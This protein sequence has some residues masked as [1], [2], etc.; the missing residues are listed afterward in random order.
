MP[1]NS[2]NN[3]N[4]K[5]NND[6]STKVGG[7]KPSV[8]PTSTS[9][10]PATSNSGE[11]E[12]N[13]DHVKDLAQ[14]SVQSLEQ[15]IDSGRKLAFEYVGSKRGDVEG[16]IEEIVK[17]SQD[18][19]VKAIDSTLSQI[20]GSVKRYSSEMGTSINAG[21]KTIDARPALPMIA[22]LIG[23]V[24][25]GLFLGSRVDFSRVRGKIESQVGSLKNDF[26]KKAA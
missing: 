2:N 1:N 5:K 13:L 23:G 4:F 18:K 3:N 8:T 21:L 6:F 12:K 7:Q 15:L 20:S 19:L 25:F 22:G 10:S 24:V 16:Y 14:D 9:T 17:L 11:F 26:T